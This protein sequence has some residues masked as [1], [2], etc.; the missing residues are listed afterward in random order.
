LKLGHDGLAF[1][2]ELFGELI[3][4]NLGHVTPVFWPGC[5]IRSTRAVATGTYSSL[6]AHRALIDF[7]TCFPLHDACA[8]R[9][10]IWHSPTT[11][12]VARGTPARRWRRAGPPGETPAGTPDVAR[13]G[14]GSAGRDAATHPARDAGPMDRG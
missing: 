14:R 8:W 2:I 7:S 12:R 9:H 10:M 4:P 11:C 5:W 1:Y 13:R 3:H 6:G